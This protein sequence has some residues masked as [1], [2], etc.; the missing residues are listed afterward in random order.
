MHHLRWCVLSRIGL[1]PLSAIP[2]SLWS[3]L[4]QLW[5]NIYSAICN[6]LQLWSAPSTL[7]RLVTNW[8][9]ATFRYSHLPLFTIATALEYIHSAIYNNLALFNALFA[10]FNYSI[11]QRTAFALCTHCEGTANP[12][13]HWVHSACT[14]GKQWDDCVLME[15]LI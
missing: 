7:V 3:Q 15:R 10:L 1:L 6:N 12:L 4:R 9:I 14:V 8:I 13:F 11:H 2:I 5:I